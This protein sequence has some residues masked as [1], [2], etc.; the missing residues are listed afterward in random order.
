MV[1]GRH[2]I[3]SS[4][5]AIAFDEMAFHLS[6]LRARGI[7]QVSLQFLNTQTRDHSVTP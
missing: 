5:A 7:F 2:A 1:G 6:A 4:P 3:E